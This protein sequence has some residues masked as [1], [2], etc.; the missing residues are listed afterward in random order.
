MFIKNRI[1]VAA[2]C[3]VEFIMTFSASAADITG[4]TNSSTLAN[5]D[6]N[7]VGN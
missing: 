3:V 2:I 4:A 7:F 6:H 5:T 1:I